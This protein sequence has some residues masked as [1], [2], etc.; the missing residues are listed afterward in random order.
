M[1]IAPFAIFFEFHSVR[2]K[3]FVLRGGIISSFALGAF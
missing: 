1:F 2:V 3:S